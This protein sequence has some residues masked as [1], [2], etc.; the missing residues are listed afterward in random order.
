[1]T[2]V[3]GNNMFIRIKRIGKDTPFLLNTSNISA[4]ETDCDNR[5]LIFLTGYYRAVL[6]S[7]S[8]RQELENL[9]DDLQ[10]GKVHSGIPYLE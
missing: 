3:G 7:S 2:I 5:G 1:M 8:V 4:V 10:N 6:V 9:L